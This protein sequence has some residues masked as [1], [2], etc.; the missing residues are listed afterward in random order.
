[1]DHGIFGSE[2]KYHIGFWKPVMCD[3][4]QDALRTIRD[5]FPCGPA[6]FEDMA[7]AGFGGDPQAVYTL[8]KMVWPSETDGTPPVGQA[9]SWATSLIAI[10]MVFLC[11]VLTLGGL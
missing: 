1:L 6:E 9:V 5:A 7:I 11:I 10:G 4:N 3:Y 2:G 8:S